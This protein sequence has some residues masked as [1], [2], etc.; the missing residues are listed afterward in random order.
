MV[1]KESGKMIIGILAHVGQGNLGD[2]AICAAV[3]E[4]IRSLVPEAE[5]VA[6]T[7]NPEDT[8]AR[9]KVRS[10]PVRKEFVKIGGT[11]KLSI[12]EK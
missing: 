4:N 3:V 9:H 11:K 2:E 7:C 1:H 12:N 6:F 10:F 8:F 5:F